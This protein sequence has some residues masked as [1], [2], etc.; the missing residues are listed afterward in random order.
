MNHMIETDNGKMGYYYREAKENATTLVFLEG[1]GGTNAY[2]NFKAVIDRLP[3]KYGILT[4][5]YLGYGLSEITTAPRTIENIRAELNN[6]IKT[7]N[8][9]KIVLFT[10]SIGG[11]YGF[12]YYLHFPEQIIG[13]VGIEPTT[14]EVLQANPQENAGFLQ[15]AEAFNQLSTEEKEKELSAVDPTGMQN[16]YLNAEDAKRDLEL[17]KEKVFNANLIDA[18][19]RLLESLKEIK[20]KKISGIL[21]TLLFSTKERT[22]AFKHSGYLSKNSL[23]RLVSLDGNH[24]LHWCCPEQLVLE[25]ERFLADIEKTSAEGSL[26]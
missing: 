14:Y 22:Q 6:V 8:L 26:E 15:A 16:P 5:D 19:Q 21:P 10:H 20:G 2:Y 4:L 25:T 24:Y 13:F 18:T 11:F 7:F 12:D 9:H 17:S 3:K 23:S 1:F